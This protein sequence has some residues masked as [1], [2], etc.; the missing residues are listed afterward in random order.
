MQLT[1]TPPLETQSANRTGSGEAKSVTAGIQGLGVEPSAHSNNRVHSLGAPLNSEA[2]T[3]IASGSNLSP[4]ELEREINALTPLTLAQK[5]AAMQESIGRPEQLT[6]EKARDTALKIAAVQYF[7]AMEMSSP[8]GINRKEAAIP[9]NEDLISTTK[10]F[11]RNLRKITI[12]QDF[13]TQE[14][15]LPATDYQ[16]KIADLKVSIKGNTQLTPLQAEQ[17]HEGMLVKILEQQL[18]AEMQSTVETYTALGKQLLTT[19]EQDRPNIE[20][21]QREVKDLH[22]RQLMASIEATIPVD[23]TMTDI[24]TKYGQA[25]KL[26][27]KPFAHQLGY[28]LD[29]QDAKENALK[30]P[31]TMRVSDV[32]IVLAKQVQA[33]TLGVTQQAAPGA[34]PIPAEP[35]KGP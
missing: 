16:R 3:A 11:Q 22:L 24:W 8:Q 4:K 20:R 2:L 27:L 23:A 10:D 32:A 31:E 15:H 29:A 5:L 6:P 14:G 21:Q 17:I 25:S 28:G 33:L 1:A 30:P 12:L 26:E 13:L 9:S 19:P 34:S 7:L 35:N 18:A